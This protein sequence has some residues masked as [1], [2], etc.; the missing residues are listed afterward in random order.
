MSSVPPV[1]V[2]EPSALSRP[3]SNFAH[4]R[5]WAA[6]SAVTNTTAAPT[7]TTQLAIALS[8][9]ADGLSLSPED[10]LAL[11]QWISSLPSDTV[12][13]F[14]K[15]NLPAVKS[16]WRSLT[17]MP[18]PMRSDKFH[19]FTPL[20]LPKVDQNDRALFR[21]LIEVGLRST[22]LIDGASRDYLEMAVKLHCEDLLQRVLDYGTVPRI[23]REAL[24]Y[25]V[26]E[27]SQRALAIL[28]AAGADVEYRDIRDRFTAL[29]HWV[30]IT[31]DKPKGT[32][33]H[34][35]LSIL[36]DAGASVDSAAK[37]DHTPS[38]LDM[39]FLLDRDVYDIL[40]PYSRAY[41]SSITVCG[42]L[43]AGENGAGPLDSYLSRHEGCQDILEY[44]L[45]AS[46][47]QPNTI[48]ALFGLG[49]EPC[50]TIDWIDFQYPSFCMG[51]T[52]SCSLWTR[53]NARHRREGS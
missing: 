21:T 7:F 25:A 51:P 22:D 44:A 23:P 28:L 16:I 49:L 17:A 13:L 46:I 26:Y 4:N 1:D 36:L 42:I 50:K 14:F 10:A 18:G 27:E 8:H 6:N 30:R 39:A 5:L 40:V 9:M 32:Y 33:R 47:R 20:P 41:K 38:I 34:D 12:R 37:D 31:S 53:N 15:I 45:V 19:W 2:I 48:K 52:S 11:R 43:E 24:I 29:G 35:I 3:A